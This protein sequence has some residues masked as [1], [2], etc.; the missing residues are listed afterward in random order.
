MEITDLYTIKGRP[1]LYKFKA[2]LR[3]GSWLFVHAIKGNKVPVTNKKSVIGFKDLV[4]FIKDE[5]NPAN[6]KK[7]PIEEVFN[8]LFEMEEKGYTIPKNLLEVQP[9]PFGWMDIESLMQDVIPGYDEGL[10]KKHHMAKIL[11]WFHEY[12]EVLDA[13]E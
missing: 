11:K 12:V 9:G 2:N 13:V 4:V 7:K 6:V 3:N 1:H 5:E 10:F 8:R